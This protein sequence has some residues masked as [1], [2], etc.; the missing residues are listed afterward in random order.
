M[1]D[2]AIGE[3]ER[4]RAFRNAIG[5]DF[6]FGHT[7]L[8]T[9]LWKSKK[10]DRVRADCKFSPDIK[11]SDRI[12]ACNNSP[13]FPGLPNCRYDALVS[14]IRRHDLLANLAFTHHRFTDSVNDGTFEALRTTFDRIARH[15]FPPAFTH[16][17]CTTRVRSEFANRMGEC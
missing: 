13:H 12:R 15:D 2:R 6:L 3:K 1:I 14:A 8:E 17:A 4:Y 7:R 10:S 5:S 9:G 16:H 11:Y